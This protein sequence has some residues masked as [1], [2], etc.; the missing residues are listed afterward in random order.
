MNVLIVDDS[1]FFRDMYKAL[2]T[3]F[4]ATCSEAG[5]GVEAI[6]LFE[7][8]L[9]QDNKFHL[10]LMD[11]SM[12]EMDGQQAL[13]TIRSVERRG[14]KQT[15]TDP[16]SAI[17]IM[18]TAHDDPQQLKLAYA[19]GGCNGYIVKSEETDD[20]LLAKLKKFNLLPAA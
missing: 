4:G 13:E 5:T 17:V 6:H 20:A 9:L 11:I 7:Q 1:K 15:A 18:L 3:P 12:P 16:D 10:I 19:Q 8:A 2:L 14:G